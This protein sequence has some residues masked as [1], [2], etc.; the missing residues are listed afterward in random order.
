M[1][2]LGM[3]IWNSLDNLLNLRVIPDKERVG[4]FLGIYNLGN[5]VTQAIAP[6]IAAFLISIIGFSSIFIMSFVLS[7]IGGIAI[8]SI[9]SVTR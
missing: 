3:G 7:I 1:A 5:T 2:G 4:L 9:K 8:L 6:V